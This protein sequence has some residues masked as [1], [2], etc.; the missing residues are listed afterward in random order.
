MATERSADQFVDPLATY[1]A[2]EELDK[3]QR[4]FKASPGQY[5]EGDVLIG[6]RMRDVF[7]LTKE[8]IDMPYGEIERLLDSP[9][10]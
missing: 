1:A 7:A 10:G 9:H 5:G 6:V 4:Y 3:L 8:F 2:P